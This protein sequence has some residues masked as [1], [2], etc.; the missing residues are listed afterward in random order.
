M[1]G[2]RAAALNG[3]LA[4]LFYNNWIAV[5]LLMPVSLFY[6]YQW[7]KECCR[8]K[9]AEFREQF[10]EAAQILSS[11][12]RVGYSVENAIRE[13]EKE[14]NSLYQKNTRIRTEF[15][16]MVRQLNMNQTAEQVLRGM[17]ERVQQEDVEDFVVIFAAAKRMGGDSI[18]ILINTIQVIGEKTDVE[19]EI[20]TLLAAKKLEFQV[21][22]MMPLGM[23][24]Y[25]RMSFPEFLSVLYGNPAG[26]ILMTVCLGVYAFAWWLGWK[27]IQIEV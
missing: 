26:M 22:C 7:R 6:L 16:R 27:M 17:A 5:F 15:E 9:E 8:K 13:T 10:R 21:M 12:L 25:M 3:L 24:L 2:G 18:G 23:V 19:R 20:Q 11:V 1:A 14:L 4:Y